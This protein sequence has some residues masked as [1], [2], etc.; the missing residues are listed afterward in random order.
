[1]RKIIFIILLCTASDSVWAIN[2]YHKLLSD[3]IGGAILPTANLISTVTQNI[4]ATNASQDLTYTALISEDGWFTLNGTSLTVNYSGV[5]LVGFSGTAY[6]SAGSGT[7]NMA[8]WM[9]INGAD[10]MVAMKN[11]VVPIL[12]AGLDVSGTFIAPLTA[13]DILNAQTW[14]DSTECSWLYVAE[15]SSPVRPKSPSIRI[16]LTKV[17][18]RI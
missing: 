4:S 11:V 8:V 6:C 16:S 12:A 2:Y 9:R 17:G 18:G 3:G 5:Y 10:T 15:G 14:S 13:G 7:K 1:M